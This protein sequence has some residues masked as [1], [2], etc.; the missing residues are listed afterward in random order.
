MFPVGFPVASGA[1]G[2]EIFFRVLAQA[3]AQLEVV[4]LDAGQRATELAAPVVARENL[5]GEFPVAFG[6]EAQMRPLPT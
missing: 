1:E 6:I 4:D 5:L 3:A 2:N